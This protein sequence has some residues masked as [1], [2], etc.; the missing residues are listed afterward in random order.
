M[1]TVRRI[2]KNIFFLSAGNIVQRILSLGM[3]IYIAQKL[4]VGD[5]GVYSFAFSFVL[6]FTVFGDLGIGVLI[7]REIAK[8]KSKAGEL[9]GDAFVIKIF[10]SLVVL[11]VV[12]VLGTLLNFF[13]GTKYFSSMFFFILIAGC[14]LLFDSMAGLFRMIFFAFQEMQYDFFVNVFYKIILVFL[15]IGVLFFGYGL[16][17]V[18]FVAVFSSFFNFILSFFVV[19]RK[20]TKLKINFNFKKYKKLVMLSL[21]FSLMYLLTAIY[22]N[23]ALIT[24]LFFK[25]NVSVGYYAAAMRLVSVIG[26]VP[27]TFMTVVFPVMASFYAVSNKSLNTVVEKSSKY[28]LI[29]VLPIAFS[30]TLLSERI[31]GLVYPTTGLNNFFPASTALTILIWLSVFNFLNMVFLNVLQS[32]VFEKRASFLFGISLIIN[33]FLSLILIPIYDFIGAAFA[34]VLS[35]LALFIL[36]GYFVSKHF[37]NFSSLLKDVI[38][39]VIASFVIFI[40]IYF[41]FFLNIFLLVIISSILYFVVLILIKGFDEKDIIF[42]KKIIERSN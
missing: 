6:I 25:G 23:I 36:G 42:F 32:T 7:S 18:F 31:I 35:E 26:F 37:L 2:G 22:G 9:L 11:I 29:I 5:F 12:F 4:G 40:F 20:F 10:L 30:T 27:A 19:T 24:L 15:T 16:K 8:D 39:C 33:I 38:K 17:E 3:V 41:F 28:L 14:S 21:P 13:Y 34:S 1:S